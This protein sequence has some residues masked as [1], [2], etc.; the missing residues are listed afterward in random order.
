MGGKFDK[1]FLIIGKMDQ[2]FD[3]IGYRRDQ[4][5]LAVQFAV[6][7]NSASN[8]QFCDRS[9]GDQEIPRSVRLR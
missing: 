1:P 6:N 3:E 5:R 9:D 4:N 2:K 7:R 8:V